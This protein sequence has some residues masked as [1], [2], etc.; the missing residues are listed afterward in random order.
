MDA[1]QVA[2]NVVEFGSVAAFGFSPLW[3]LAAAADILNGTRIYLRTLEEELTG[4]GILAPDTHFGSLDQLLGALEGTAGTTASTIDLPP[5]EL[6]ELK[7]S[8][9][10]LRDDATSLPSANELA[11][12]F[13]GLLRTAR[14]EDR[15]LLEVSSG[16]G[17]AFLV[18]AK[19]VTRTHLVT[20][21]G[22]DWRPVRQEGFGAYAARVS[23]PYREA[24]SGHFDP[25]KRSFTERIL[26]WARRPHGG[27]PLIRRLRRLMARPK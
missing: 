24:V 16:V 27:R 11:S 17:L 3:L 21:Y 25:G 18:S 9:R 8:V 20:P 26:H 5:L 4:A 1:P 14:Q 23:G 10:E 7:R 19:K 15:S 6:A 2:G 12:L 22:E 13:N